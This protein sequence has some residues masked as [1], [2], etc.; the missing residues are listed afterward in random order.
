MHDLETLRK[1]AKFWLKQVRSNHSGFTKR[2]RLAY[3]DA[4]ADPTLRDI[5]HALARELGY[6]S[7]KALQAD[8]KADPK[9]DPKADLKV[10]LYMLASIPVLSPS[11]SCFTPALSSMVT[12][13]FVIGVWSG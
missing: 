8:A 13:R 6:E 7:W 3:P 10:G 4:P 5:Q 11:V 1:D 12:S 2:L 9:A